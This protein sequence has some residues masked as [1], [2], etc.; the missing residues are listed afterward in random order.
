M[1]KQAVFKRLGIGTEL[2]LE[3]FFFFLLLRKKMSWSW[4]LNSRRGWRGGEEEIEMGGGEID[5]GFCVRGEI[6]AT[7]EEEK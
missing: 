1:L 3:F 2:G 4:W 7:E 5:D 6:G